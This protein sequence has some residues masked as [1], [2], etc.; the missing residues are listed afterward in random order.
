V[1][2][3]QNKFK[4]RNI[5]PKNNTIYQGKEAYVRIDTALLQ[6][7][8][9]VKIIGE[10]II[11]DEVVTKVQRKGFEI[12]YLAYFFDIF[13]EL[14]GQK[15]KILKYILENKDYNNTLII[16]VRELAA[17]TK[18]STNTVNGALKLLRERGIIK[19][20]V[21]SIMLLPKVALKG[22][23][24]KEMHLMRKFKIFEQTEE[25]NNTEDNK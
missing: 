23:S 15:Y 7:T 12:T 21:G 9:E 3:N 24:E 10:P 22:S 11:A 6:N 1:Q 25:E 20:R 4:R 13:D 19:T 8:G 18:T 14:G 16:T 2:K 5:M 17:K